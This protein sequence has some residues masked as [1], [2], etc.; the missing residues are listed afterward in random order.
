MFKLVDGV[1]KIYA[2]KGKKVVYLDIRK[3]QPNP[4]T[5]VK[6]PEY[7]ILFDHAS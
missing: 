6:L 5:L 4:A 2:A 1:N 7:E 3:E